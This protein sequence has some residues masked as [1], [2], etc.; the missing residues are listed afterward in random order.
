M[1]IL[2]TCGAG[3][4]TPP[5]PDPSVVQTEE[6]KAPAAQKD[7]KTAI[8]Q[9]SAIAGP[10]AANLVTVA[11][12]MEI[13]ANAKGKDNSG[14]AKEIEHL[15]LTERLSSP[16]LSLLSAEL[17]GKESRTALTAIGDAS[18]FLDP[19]A[20]EVANE[21]APS[22]AERDHMMSMVLD[23]LKR[24]IPKL[25]DF[26]AKRFTTSF[27]E[28]WKP[29]DEVGIHKRIALHSAGES[30]AT[31]YYREGKEV[32]REERSHEHGLI[33]RGTFGPILRVVVLDAAQSNTMQWSRWEEGPNGSMA[34]FRF[35]VPQMRSHY[36]VS[37]ALEFGMTGPTAYHGEIGIDPTSGTILRL[38]LQA[39]PNLGATI[40]RAGI[41]V[42]YG[43]VVIGGKSYTCPVRS[44]SYSVGLLALFTNAAKG[45]SWER[46]AAR[47][48]DV[49]FRDY[50]VFRSQMRI[51]PD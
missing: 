34:V 22:M 7:E 44:V 50:H 25:P 41:L 45:N 9:Q 36:E 37:G 47:L 3:G 31:V 8:A 30:E 19:P 17:P 42:E 1:I 33:T 6:T 35:Q 39:D 26:Y 20:N 21:P 14:T 27:V 18:V 28:V 11:Q 4:Q 16:K 38:M 48:N 49:K 13:V 24:I 29:K 23:Y 32:V 43:S 2:R 46:K 10:G 12:L 5:L 15:Q 40:E 51:L